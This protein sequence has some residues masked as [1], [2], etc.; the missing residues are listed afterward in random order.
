MDKATLLKKAQEAQ[1]EALR[2]LSVSAE[3]VKAREWPK[4]TN[5]DHES[6]RLEQARLQGRAGAFIEIIQALDV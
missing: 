5:S 4:A 6:N 2:L 3:K 1:D